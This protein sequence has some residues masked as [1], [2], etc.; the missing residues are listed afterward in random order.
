MGSF[1]EERIIQ[2]LKNAPLSFSERTI[3]KSFCTL[4]FGRVIAHELAGFQNLRVICSKSQ[5]SSALYITFRNY[6]VSLIS[7]PHTA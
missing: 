5:L 2:E 6:F 1:D 4:L 3:E 7:F